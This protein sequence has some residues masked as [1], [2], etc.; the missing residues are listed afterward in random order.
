LAPVGDAGVDPLKVVKQTHH[1]KVH[2][3][4]GYDR[5]DNDVDDHAGDELL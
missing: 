3:R 5:R 1:V 2:A 4:M